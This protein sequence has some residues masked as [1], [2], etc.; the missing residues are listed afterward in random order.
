VKKLAYID[1]LRGMAVLLVMLSHCIQFGTNN[2][3]EILTLLFSKSEY[4]VQLFYIAS[5]FTLFLSFKSRLNKENSPK[6]YFFIRRFFRIAP[7]YYIAIIFY[8]WQKNPWV[9]N[10]PDTGYS[11]ILSHV[12]FIHGFSPLWMNSLV[13]GGWSVG[14]E[15]LF[16]LMVPFLF[17]RIKNL[18]SAALFLVIA[19]LVQYICN[20]YFIRHPLIADE[21]I[22][23]R[24]LYCYLPSQLP[25]FALGIILFHLLNTEN[26]LISVKPIVTLSIFLI[27]ILQFWLEINLM[28][29]FVFISI[30]FT[31][32]AFSFA[33]LT[34]SIFIN[35]VINYIGKVSYSMYLIHFA[36]LELMIRYG[37]ADIITTNSHYTLNLMLRLTIV[38]IVTVI[39]SS[40]FYY[41]V[42]KPMQKMGARLI[43]KLEK[44]KFYS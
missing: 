16:Y 4:G 15:M 39:F 42:E 2:Y 9:D 37:I 33:K 32:L 30:G 26:S 1:S 23:I 40:I 17:S 38:V 25:V 24:Y 6:L 34:K 41:A 28:P 36:V 11:K 22:W 8:L 19:V 3:G 10:L 35:P 21:T 20:Y 14:L 44:S 12:F 43:S 7:M 18:N 13:P 29:E 31:F 5:A 27:I